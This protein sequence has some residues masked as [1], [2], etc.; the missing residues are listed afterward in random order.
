VLRSALRGGELYWRPPAALE[1]RVRGAVRHAARVET[2]TH[3]WTWWGLRV[4]AA[5]AVAVLVWNLV[6]RWTGPSA[7]DRVI[8]PAVLG[9]LEPGRVTGLCPG[10]AT[11]HAAH[12]GD[13]HVTEVSSGRATLICHQG[14]DQGIRGPQLA[15]RL[16]QA[17]RACPPVAAPLHRQESV[18]RLCR[19]PSISAY[20][21]PLARSSACLCPISGS[22]GLRRVFAI[23]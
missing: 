1:K 21:S 2:P 23:L 22:Y 9:D 15:N 18:P 19:L 4:A 17:V 10:G 16:G 13:Q 7:D 20:L 12:P 14:R 11:G 3:P 5:L 6:P 8:Q